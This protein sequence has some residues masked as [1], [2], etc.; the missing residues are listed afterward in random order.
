[1]DEMSMHDVKIKSEIRDPDLDSDIFKEEETS[2]PENKIN[3]SEPDNG[4]GKVIN[5]GSDT[6]KNPIFQKV[7]QNWL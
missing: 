1:M 4:N 7:L 2:Y 5:V 6:F 3:I